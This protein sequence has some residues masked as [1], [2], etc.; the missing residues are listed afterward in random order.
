MKSVINEE[1]EGIKVDVFLFFVL[2]KGVLSVSLI[3]DY[4]ILLY[5]MKHLHS[6][7]PVHFHFP[8]T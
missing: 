2:Y 1:E 8:Q 6:K 5:R 4:Y 7:L 3:Q